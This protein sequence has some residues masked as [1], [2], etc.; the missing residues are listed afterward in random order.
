MATPLSAPIADATVVDN[1]WK[2]QKPKY[3][4]G[5]CKSGAPADWNSPYLSFQ[6]LNERITSRLQLADGCP[7]KL[8]L[9][10][11]GGGDTS[12]LSDSAYQ[13]SRSDDSKE[14]ADLTRLGERLHSKLS[15]SE[16]NLLT[17]TAMSSRKSKGSNANRLAKR[18][19]FKKLIGQ[20]L[21]KNASS[22]SHSSQDS[23]ASGSHYGTGTSYFAPFDQNFILK[24]NT[25]NAGLGEQRLLQSNMK[26]TLL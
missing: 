21:S 16:A 18:K 12:P 14:Q 6:F 5:K 10:T 13:T 3:E 24:R 26:G 25:P 22:S 8:L 17:S 1:P 9:A 23:L 2:L 11:N 7:S 4:T 15:C 20:Y 19:S